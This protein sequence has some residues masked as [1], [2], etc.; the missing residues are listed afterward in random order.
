MTHTA[1]A[2]AAEAEDAAAAYDAHSSAVAAEADAA[3]AAYGARSAVAVAE[4]RKLLHPDAF[5]ALSLTL[6]NKARLLLT[7]QPR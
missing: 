7:L 4:D 2:V 3:A 1:V 6:K 5:A